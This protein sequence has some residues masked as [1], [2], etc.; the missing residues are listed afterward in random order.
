MPVCTVSHETKKGSIELT[1]DP[2]KSAPY[3]IAV[4][5]PDSWSSDRIFGLFFSGPNALTITTDRQSIEGK[6]LTVRD[7]GFGNVLN[8][9]QY[10]STV[11][12]FVGDATVSFSLDDAAPEI[13]RF[14]ECLVAPIA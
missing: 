3:A 14:R 8:G 1:Y 2:A 9:L 13:A 4:T 7:Q 12:A 5:N 10:N 6:T 11:T